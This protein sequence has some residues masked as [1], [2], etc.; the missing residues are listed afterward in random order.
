MFLCEF[1][2]LLKLLAHELIS[3]KKTSQIETR[4]DLAS[5]HAFIHF[6]QS[7]ACFLLKCFSRFHITPFIHPNPGKLKNHVSQNGQKFE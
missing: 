6:S 3:M 4:L 7:S 5:A 1:L 2:R